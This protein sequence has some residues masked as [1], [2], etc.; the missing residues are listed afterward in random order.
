MSVARFT[1]DL[2]RFDAKVRARARAVVKT[3]AVECAKNVI[4][5]GEYAP[6]TPV[7]TGFARGNW[8]VATGEHGGGAGAPDPGGSKTLDAA[9]LTIVGTSGADSIFILN[10]TVY[11][12]ELEYGHS[13][14]APSGMVRLT[15]NAGQRIVEGAVHKLGAS[16]GRP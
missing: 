10:N 1:A 9:V 13:R 11:I 3:V 4:V 6:G 7:D 5:G 8:W 15:L 14:Q 12:R 2:A 16:D